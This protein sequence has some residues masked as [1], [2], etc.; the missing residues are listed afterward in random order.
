MERYGGT[1]AYGT[2]RAGFRKAETMDTSE[3]G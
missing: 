2:P 3:E 1:E